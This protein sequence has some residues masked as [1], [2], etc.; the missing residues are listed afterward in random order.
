MTI[1]IPGGRS[2]VGTLDEA[3]DR[4]TGGNRDGNRAGVQS[5]TCVIACPPHPQHGGDRQD[6]RLVAVAD[7]VT[8]HGADCLRI[9]YGAWDHGYG[10]RE[11]IR[12]AVRW[13]ADRYDRVGLFGY[14]FGGTMSLLAA[15]SVEHPICAVSTLAP[16]P[17][18]ADD[19]DAMSAVDHIDCP[20]QIIYGERD[21]TVDSEP[22]ADAIRASVDDPMVQSFGADHF[23]V[24]QQN[25]IAEL[26]GSFCVTHLTVEEADPS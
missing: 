18:L 8:A 6:A 16:A 9:D 20:V 26:V 24:G 17:R 10:E 21:N 15:A 5:D 11:D 23:F 3:D 13:A 1:S 22:L 4:N 2:V 14:S 19:L 25:K 7:E 12:N